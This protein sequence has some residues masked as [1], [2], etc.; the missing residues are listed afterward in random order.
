MILRS[1]I[2][3]VTLTFAALVMPS[4]ASAAEGLT[5]STTTL[6]AGPGTD[7]PRVARVAG[8]ATLEIFGCLARG[9][10]CDVSTEGERGWL[11][12]S[13]IDFL[14]SGRRTHLSGNFAG[15]GLA[16]LSFGQSDY[17][18]TH[19]AGRP[20]VN[21]RRRQRGDA[22]PST[23]SPQVH[24]GDEQPGRALHMAPPPHMAAPNAGALHQLRHDPSSPR[25]APKQHQAPRERP[26]EDP[27]R[28]GGPG[29]PQ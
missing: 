11:P 28:H 17:W 10:W 20:W 7:Y 18:G 21:D 9:S 22:A 4:L 3:A 8:G 12:G 5:R 24:P 19:Y 27:L 14:D 26:T 15:L 29:A 16:I 23:E 2:P 13:R 25:P 1:L 6:R